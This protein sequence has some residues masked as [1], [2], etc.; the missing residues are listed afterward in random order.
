MQG[1]LF[2]AKNCTERVINFL[3]IQHNKSLHFITNDD[4][5]KLYYNPTKYLLITR[6]NSCTT[7]SSH[8]KIGN[9]KIINLQVEF[10]SIVRD[11]Y[12]VKEVEISQ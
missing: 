7:N 12:L 8:A 1:V 10:T 9:Y 2:S 3:V 6:R 4:T 5:Y 11:F